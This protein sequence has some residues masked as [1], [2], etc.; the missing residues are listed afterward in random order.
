M[1]GSLLQVHCMSQHAHLHQM[2]TCAILDSSNLSQSLR[3]TMFTGIPSSKSNKQNCS[4]TRCTPYIQLQQPVMC[5]GGGLLASLPKD[6]TD[7]C[8]QQLREAGYPH[9]RLIGHVTEGQGK[10]RLL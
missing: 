7:T 1:H 9:A 8:I 10:V 3:R 2:S 4:C 5:A 6:A